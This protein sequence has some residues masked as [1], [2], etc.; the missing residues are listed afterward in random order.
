MTTIE[1]KTPTLSLSVHDQYILAVANENTMISE[2]EI[3]FLS[4]VAKK[5]F[6]GPFGVLEV[7]DKSISIDPE[8]HEKAKQAMPNFAAY[9]LVTN[10]VS[11][12]K[13][14]E[15][16]EPF[17]KYEDFRLCSSVQ[18]ATEWMNFILPEVAA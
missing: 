7:R 12:I 18:E 4:T 1:Y 17:M 3:S 2:K 15:K 6:S 8:V 14:L 5:H 11:A 10:K 13:S 9:A 16:E